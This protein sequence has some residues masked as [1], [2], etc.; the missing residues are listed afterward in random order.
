M[1]QTS[2]PVAR[3]APL[4]TP[5][6]DEDAAGIG[7]WGHPDRTYEPLLLVRCLQRHPKLANRLRAL[8]EALY[9]ETK[10]PARVRTIAILRICALVGCRYEWGGQAAFW[11]PIAGVSD[12]E[13]DAL[14]IENDPGWTAAERVLIASVDELE[15]TGSWS[16]KTW[17]ALGRDLD[18]EQSMELL[19]AVGWY[20][21]VCTL[22]NGLDL[23][24]EGWMRPW[25]TAIGVAQDAV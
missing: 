6:S 16:A 1:A 12:D 20:R 3:V 24:V 11:G 18:D 15:R 7:R 9:T 25:P 5:W 22:C 23:P 2:N 14:V 10:L 21:T 8:G 17:A 4:A 19:I 13:C